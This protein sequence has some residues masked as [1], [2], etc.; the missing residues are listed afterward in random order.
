[1]D[2][3]TISMGYAEHAD[4]DETSNGIW[5]RLFGFGKNGVYT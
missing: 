3:K 4:T 1:M 5:D 2:L